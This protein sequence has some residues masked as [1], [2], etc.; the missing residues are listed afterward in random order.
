M[1]ILTQQSRQC[2][3]IHTHVLQQRICHLKEGHCHIGKAQKTA[4]CAGG[5]HKKPNVLRRR[6]NK[7]FTALALHSCLTWAQVFSYFT[8][9]SLFPMLFY[10]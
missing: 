5:L 4:V 7:D 2:Q 9:G 6:C 8:Q 10:N 3:G 1:L